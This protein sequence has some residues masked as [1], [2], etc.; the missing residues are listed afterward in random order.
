MLTIFIALAGAVIDSGFG[1][2][3]IQRN[4]TT[5]E[6]ECSVFYF[7]IFIAVVVY[8]ML[9]WAAPSIAIFY[10]EPQLAAI[11]QVT[12]LS[13]IIGSFSQVQSIFFEKDEFQRTFQTQHNRKCLFRYCWCYYG[14]PWLWNLEPSCI[15]AHC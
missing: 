2:A 5:I 13:L 3:L 9:F 10:K 7:N 6:D 1:N 12:S 14:L 11:F 4:E 8:T 15:V